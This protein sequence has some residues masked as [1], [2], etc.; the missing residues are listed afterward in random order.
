M[1]PVVKVK[2][3]AGENAL[4]QIREALGMTQMEFASAI[5][6]THRSIV[7]W[8]NGQTKPQFSIPQMKAL[9]SEMEKVGLTLQDLPDDL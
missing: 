6:A 5:K 1:K 3:I 2:L 7:R 4:K 9:V 8:E